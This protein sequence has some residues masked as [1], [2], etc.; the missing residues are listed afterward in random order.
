MF[1]VMLKNMQ[2][3]PPE[4]R[5]LGPF[6]HVRLLYN[7]VRVEDA[8]EIVVRNTSD[9]ENDDMWVCCADGSVWSEVVFGYQAAPGLNQGK[10]CC[11]GEA[12][13]AKEPAC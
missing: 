6:E 11:C 12:A 7:C 9:P 4:Q 2:K 8:E 13:A 10:Y 1:Y 5:E 3:T